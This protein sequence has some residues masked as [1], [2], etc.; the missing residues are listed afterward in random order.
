MSLIRLV[1]YSETMMPTSQLKY[2]SGNDT[3]DPHE[4]GISS[5]DSTFGQPWSSV[6]AKIVVIL[7]GGAFVLS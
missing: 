7:Y 3:N 1:L 2:W 6:F 4:V 5:T